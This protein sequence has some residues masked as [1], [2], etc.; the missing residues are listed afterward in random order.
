MS[1]PPLQTSSLQVVGTSGNIVIDGGS[2]DEGAAEEHYAEAIIGALGMERR[3]QV[4]S[5]L[6][7]TRYVDIYQSGGAQEA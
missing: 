5:R 4:L 1:Q 2:D 7:I 6:Y 3:N